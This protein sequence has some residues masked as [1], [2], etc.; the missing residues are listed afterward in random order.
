MR[1]QG[2]NMSDP[3]SQGTFQSQLAASGIDPNSPQFKQAL[4][5]CRSLLPPGNGFGTGH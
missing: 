1:K 3:N 5:S 4:Y 2:V